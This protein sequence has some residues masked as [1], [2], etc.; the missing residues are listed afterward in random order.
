MAVSP[1]WNNIQ[2]RREQTVKKIPFAMSLRILKTDGFQAYV[3]IFNLRI[4][5]KDLQMWASS[6]F[7]RFLKYY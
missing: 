3:I 6:R 5:G 2:I 4:K 1:Y 7:L